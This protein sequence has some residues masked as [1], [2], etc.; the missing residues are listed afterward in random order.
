MLGRNVTE[1]QIYPSRPLGCDRKS[2]PTV[3]V[4]LSTF[5]KNSVIPSEVEES[6][7]TSEGRK[8]TK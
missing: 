7:S 2:V 8:N 4:L 1:G 5:S 6:L 3:T